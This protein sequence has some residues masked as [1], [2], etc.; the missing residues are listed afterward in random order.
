MAIVFLVMAV[1]LSVGTGAVLAAGKL[2]I[3]VNKGIGKATLGMTQAAAIKTIGKASKTGKDSEYEGRVVYF[4]YYGKANA[5]GEYPLEVYSDTKKKVFLFEMNSPAYPTDA[6]IKIGS[7]EADLKKAYG[8]KLTCK[9]GRLYTNY[10]LGGK[11]GTDFFVKKGLVT[12]I[13]V[14]SY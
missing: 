5:K 12:Q 8:K 10:T 2:I 4:A 1:A 14:R 13:L 9:K 3:H 7:K 11:T 6:G